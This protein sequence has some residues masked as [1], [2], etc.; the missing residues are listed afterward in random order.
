MPKSKTADQHK[1][2]VKALKAGASIKDALLTGGY[3]ESSAK[4]GYAMIAGSKPLRK[5]IRR[6]GMRLMDVGRGVSDKDIEYLIRGRL[7]ENI[8][9][10][11]DE[12][13]HS[14]KVAGQMIGI[15]QDEKV[16]V[17]VIMPP[18]FAQAVEP[19][20]KQLEAPAIDAIPPVTEE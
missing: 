3:T 17:A 8:Q 20:L 2:V 15:L 13:V 7:V 4:R 6:S 9:E 11:V 1:A 14:V 18:A 12:A 19:D 16:Q 5:A 10:G